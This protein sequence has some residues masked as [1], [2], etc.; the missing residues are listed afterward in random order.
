MKP[1]PDCSSATTAA[2]AAVGA[3]TAR[4]AADDPQRFVPITRHVEAS[5]RENRVSGAGL[6]IV[7]K[8]G[9]TVYERYFGDWTAQKTAPIASASKWFAAATVLTLVDAGLVKLDD[10]VEKYL[11]EFRN[12]GKKSEITLRQTLSFTTGF[13]PHDRIVDD[14]NLMLAEV[15]RRISDMELQRDPGTAFTYGGLQMMIAGRVAEV[16]TGK[17]YRTVFEERLVAPLGL[18]NTRIATL[19]GRSPRDLVF[20]SANPLVPGGVVTHVG[21]FRKFVVMLLNEGMHEGRRI[22]SPTAVAEMKK[23]QTGDLPARRTIQEDGSYHY[24]LGGWYRAIGPAAGGA[25][26]SSEG[27]L[28]TS[29]WIYSDANYGVVFMTFARAGRMKEF[30]WRLKDM[31]T[32]ILNGKIVATMSWK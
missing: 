12:K 17:P 30:R 22:L 23:D 14:P 26:V 24:S 18:T 3:A 29:G 4:A 6:L 2:P 9:R 7:D 20:D 28:G 19:R 10:R 13:K 5:L 31:V 21:D 15:V 32:E 25:I 1:A 27:A 8:Q 11:P 16:V